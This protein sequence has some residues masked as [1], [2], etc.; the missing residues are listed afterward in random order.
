LDE[1]GVVVDGAGVAEGS[2]LAA[3]T[4]ATPPVT[5]RAPA[6]PAVR[7]A[8]RRPSG[9]R[10]CDV[11]EVVGGADV[12]GDRVSRSSQAIWVVSF[13]DRRMG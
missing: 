6:I 4:T 1:P 11:V 8:R 13:F 12:A 5:S 3:N 10:T 2:G 9:R 7:R